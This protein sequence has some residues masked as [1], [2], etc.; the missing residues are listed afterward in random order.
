MRGLPAGEEYSKGSTN[1]SWWQGKRAWVQRETEQLL[2]AQ[3]EPQGNRVIQA[4]QRCPPFLDPTIVPIEAAR[5][6]VQVWP[7]YGR[8]MVFLCPHSGHSRNYGFYSRSGSH[9][10]LC[11]GFYAPVLAIMVLFWLCH[12]G[13]MAPFWLLWPGQC[14]QGSAIRRAPLLLWLVIV[15]ICGGGSNDRGLHT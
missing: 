11:Y 9:F 3:C 7:C 4:L 2:A 6:T 14:A 8:I 1:E 15:P 12:R 10:R 5:N 13:I